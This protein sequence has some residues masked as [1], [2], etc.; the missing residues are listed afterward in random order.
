MRKIHFTSISFFKVFTEKK[1]FC[2]ETS[3][4]ETC[5]L[6]SDLPAKLQEIF[7]QLSKLVIYKVSVISGFNME[8]NFETFLRNVMIWRHCINEQIFKFQFL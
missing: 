2:R 7:P 5:R 3:K 6:D 1:L 4:I 8:W